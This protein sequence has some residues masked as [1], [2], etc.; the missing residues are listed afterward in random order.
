MVRIQSISDAIKDTNGRNYKLVT[1]EAPA[2]KEM[3]DLQT[4][5]SV[6]AL[7]SPKTVKKCVW[8]KNYLDQTKHVFYDAEIGQA[9]YGSIHTASTDEYE[10]EGKD[11]EIRKVNTYTGFIE[12]LPSDADFDS[13]VNSMLTSAGRELAKNVDSNFEVTKEHQPSNEV[14]ELAKE[15]VE[16][17][18]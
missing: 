4:G 12:A 17:Q 18:F 3:T 1:L 10:I 16:E 13:K 5:E 14:E 15:S 11:G 8:E 2:F 9:V 6:L 7:A